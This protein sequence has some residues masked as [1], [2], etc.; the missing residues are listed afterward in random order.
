[1]TDY[2]MAYLF[3]DNIN[4]LITLLMSFSSV[5]FAFL[6]A[7]NIVAHKLKSSM[8]LLVIALFTIASSILI[9]L[10]NRFGNQFA[11]IA[12]L[13]RE[14]V[15]NGSSSLGWH[16][17]TYE[18]AVL[19][20]FLMVTFQTLMILLYIGALIFFFHQRREGLKSD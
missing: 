1:M 19:P 6:V 10:M 17:I 7:G 14:A 2:E 4:I 11:N 15:E 20:L 5:V 13:M 16:P 9:F 8:V 12:T 18:P 3:N